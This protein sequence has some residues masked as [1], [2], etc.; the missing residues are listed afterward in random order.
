LEV[1]LPSSGVDK[2][3]IRHFDALAVLL[4]RRGSEADGESENDKS[5]AKKPWQTLQPNKEG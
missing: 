2:I 3:K 1:I 4:G 5:M